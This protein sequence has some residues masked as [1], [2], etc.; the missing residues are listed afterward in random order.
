MIS[1]T[2]RHHGLFEVGRDKDL[3]DLMANFERSRPRSSVLFPRWS[4]SL[5]LKWL[6]SEEFEP[7]AQSSLRNLTLKTCFLVALASASRVSELHAL[8]S[9]P[10][11]LQFSDDGS[12]RLL[13]EPG[14]VAK[15]RLPSVGSQE[16]IIRPLPV[17]SQSLEYCHDPVRALS[18]YLQ[19]TKGPKRKSSRLF[20]SW[21]ESK[22]DISPQTISAWLRM[23]IK[24]AYRAAGTPLL[25][26]ENPKAHE[27]RAI[28]SSLAFDR[29]LSTKDII[30]AVGWRSQS[31][32]GT[33]YLRDMSSE[34]ASLK[35]LGPISASQLVSTPIL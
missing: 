29:N 8:S 11:F 5:V 30:Q 34:R 15:N 3:S 4:L 7:L 21:A 18:C 31:T 25:A 9:D 17:S 35:D 14:F 20:Q 13:T 19:R 28:A 24:T 27:V 26:S 22:P 16:I 6:N 1:D 10:N 23:V 32:F 33:F 12:V 2:Y